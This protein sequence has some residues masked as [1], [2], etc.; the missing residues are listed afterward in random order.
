MKDLIYDLIH[1]AIGLVGKCLKGFDCFTWE[2]YGDSNERFFKHVEK[3]LNIF[4]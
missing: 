4:A 2:G 3:I 1:R